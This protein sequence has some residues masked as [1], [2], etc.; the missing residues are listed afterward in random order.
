MTL[1]EQSA[2]R[3]IDR[4]IERPII[5]VGAPRSGTSILFQVLSTHP[6]LW[7]LYRESQPI[8]EANFDPRKRGLESNVLRADD[9]DEQTRVHL[10]REFFRRVGNI[11]RLLPPL[12]RAIPLIARVKL[13]ALM[14]TLGQS[15]KR[16]P[17]R[18]VE[19]TPENSFRIPF[20]MKLFPDALFL[21]VIRDPRGSISSI[22]R[23]WHQPVKFK[24]YPL[25]SGFHIQGYEGKRWSFGLPPGWRS[26]DGSTLMEVCAFQW[27]AYNEA[28]LQDLPF[29]Q[30][31]VLQVGYEDLVGAPAS[32]LA[33]VA[34]WAGVDY[35]SLARFGARLPVVNT[36]SRPSP[37]KWEAHQREIARVL[38][39]VADVA[40][41]LGY[42]L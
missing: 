12:S 16:S 19:K 21:Y 20:L 26:Y 9:L 25:P 23:G 34:A 10:E 6:D 35:A 13:S 39:T 3:R 11:E 1:G 29:A 32:Q 24:T 42:E 7:S 27:K 33:R 4:L 40:S 36:R 15:R 38:P 14:V 41:R 31:N 30:G 17:L 18:I 5:I 8:I 37:D 2:D 22:Y 28:C